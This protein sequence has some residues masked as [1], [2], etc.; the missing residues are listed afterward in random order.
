MGERMSVIKRRFLTIP[1]TVTK[2]EFVSR[3]TKLQQSLAQLWG[4]VATEITL[5]RQV[6][7]VSTNYAS[8]ETLDGLTKHNNEGKRVVANL[9]ELPDNFTHIPYL[10]LYIRPEMN[11]YEIGSPFVEVSFGLVLPS[12]IIFRAGGKPLKP[13]RE[14]LFPNRR[15]P[16]GIRFGDGF[17]KNAIA[18][19]WL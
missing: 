8:D 16:L 19:N 10:F 12:H 2:R 14:L 17:E 18:A 15:I 11:N 5:L 9:Q 7:I 6:P 3:V 1:R 13:L 4:P